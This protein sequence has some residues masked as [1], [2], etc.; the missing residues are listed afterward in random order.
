MVWG[1]TNA[2]GLDIEDKYVN[3]V[4]GGRLMEALGLKKAIMDSQQDFNSLRQDETVEEDFDDSYDVREHMAKSQ[5]ALSGVTSMNEVIPPENFSHVVGEVYRSSFPRSE[6][7][8]F[9]KERIKLR[10]ILVLIP[11]TYPQENVEFMRR[12]GIQL[13][14][15]GM[16]GN[17]EPFVNIPSD[18]LTKALEIAINPSNHPILIHCNRGKHRTGC[19]VGCIRKLQNWSLTMIFDEYRRFAFPKAR[20]MDQQFIEM[21]NNEELVA[22]ANENKWLPVKW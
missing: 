10:S 21:Y 11:E 6:N 7:F 18:L 2:I 17:K 15:I 3:K 9:L 5:E 22:V 8:M 12:A 16:S 1:I 20:A 4:K 19:L 13:F 14:Q